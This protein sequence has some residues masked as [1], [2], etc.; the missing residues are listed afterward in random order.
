MNGEKEARGSNV[1]K[2]ANG[3][4]GVEDE[5]EDRG[6]SEGR[7]KGEWRKKEEREEG[8]KEAGRKK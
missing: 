2:K 8:N 5:K 4:K 7:V 6:W 1:T 3:K